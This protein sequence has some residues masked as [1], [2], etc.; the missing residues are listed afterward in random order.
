DDS[1][2]KIVEAMRLARKNRHILWQNIGLAL[3]VKL[4]FV[5]LGVIGK[6]SMWEAVFA[7]M[8]VALLAI[9]NAARMLKDAKPSKIKAQ[10]GCGCG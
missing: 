7:D 10:C 3:L 4:A 1:L 2:G 5:A 8:G 9:A 6:A